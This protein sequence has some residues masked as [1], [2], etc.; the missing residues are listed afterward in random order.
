TFVTGVMLALLSIWSNGIWL[1]QL[2]GQLILF[3][4]LLLLMAIMLPEMK[5]GLILLL[6]MLSSVVSHAPGDIRYYSLYHRRR[7]ESL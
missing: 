6:I 2:R 7:I 1:I 3:K 5:F 4:L